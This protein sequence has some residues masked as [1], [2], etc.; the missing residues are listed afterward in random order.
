MKLGIAHAGGKLPLA[1]G[2]QLQIIILQQLLTIFAIVLFVTGLWLTVS[3]NTFNFHNTKHSHQL[4]L[5]V[6]AA[7]VTTS[8]VFDWVGGG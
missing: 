8:N 3:Y 6:N 1:T 2:N 5:F 4:V 7:Q